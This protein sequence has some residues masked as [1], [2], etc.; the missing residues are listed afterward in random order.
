MRGEVREAYV[1]GARMG[2]GW[3]GMGVDGADGRCVVVGGRHMDERGMRVRWVGGGE[4][5]GWVR[6]DCEQRAGRRG[7]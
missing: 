7:W 4:R 5:L 3:C 6:G 1:E 2:G